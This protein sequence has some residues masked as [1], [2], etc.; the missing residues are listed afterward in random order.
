MK[1]RHLLYIFSMI[2]TLILAGCSTTPIALDKRYSFPE[3]E[4]VD[5]ITNYRVSGWQSVDSRSLI[6]EDLPSTYYLVILRNQVRDLNSS[7]VI[8]LTST[9]TQI[10]AGFDCVQVGTTICTASD[11]A[12]IERIYKLNGSENLQYVKS[13][14]RRS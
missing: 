9:G 14:I 8:S 6:I 3:F 4:Q 10:Q 11:A 1:N 13:K 12:P 7:E 2:T 5:S